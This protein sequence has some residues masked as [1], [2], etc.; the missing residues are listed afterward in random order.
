MKAL[1]DFVLSL[2]WVALH[3][4]GICRVL[5]KHQTGRL[6]IFRNERNSLIGVFAC[7]GDPDLR[8]QAIDEL[9]LRA[10]VLM[11]KLDELTKGANK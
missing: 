3:L 6:F 2:G 4:P 10:S 9:T 8:G 11:R 1:V 7:H 5:W